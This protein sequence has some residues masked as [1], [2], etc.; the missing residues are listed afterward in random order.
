MSKLTWIFS[1]VLVC[2][3]FSSCDCDKALENVQ[4][5][6]E[7]PQQSSEV[8]LESTVR[9]T[10]S[11]PKV[12]V[13]VLVHPL[14]T[15]QWWVQ[16]SPSPTNQDGSWRTSCFLG[17]ETE[18]MNEEFELL[19]LATTESLTEGQIFKELP[20]CGKRSDIVTVKRT[21]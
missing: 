12:R 7:S 1:L 2:L 13:Y 18:G 5:K 4:I 16:R 3:T 14:K 15:N 6:I 21:R 9:G 10:V 20:Q 19:A 17:T 8:S 11:D